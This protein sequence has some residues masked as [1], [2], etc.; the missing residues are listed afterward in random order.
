M[1]DAYALALKEMHG[2][3]AIPGFDFENSDYVISFGSGLIDGWGAPVRMFRVHSS[4]KQRGVTLVQAEPRLSN[5][6]AKADKWLPIQPGTEAVLALGLAWVILTEGLYDRA[7]I[8]NQTA[9]FEAWKRSVIDNY[10]PDTVSGLTGISPEVIQ[11]VARDFAGSKR[12]VAVCGRGEGRTPASVEEVTA[13]HALNALVGNI[14]KRGGIRAFSELAY[15]RWPEPVM[16]AAAMNSLKAPRIDGAGGGKYPDTPHLLNRVPGAIA[17]ESGLEI[18][19]LFVVNA[20]PCYTLSDASAV[21]KAF[22]GIPYKVSFSTYMDETAE[23]ADLVLPNHHYLERYED[24]H[25]TAGLT[26]PIMGLARPVVDPQL[27]TRHTGDVIIDIAKEMK[28]SMAASFRWGSYTACLKQALGSRWNYLVRRGYL[29]GTHRT[30]GFTAATGKFEFSTVGGSIF[31]AP[32]GDEA[33]F[34]LLLVPN[35][36]MRL[37]AGA[38]GSP[39]F[40]VKTVSETVLLENDTLVEIHPATAAAQGLTDSQ[41]A[42]LKTPRGEKKVKVHL[43]EG[44]RPGVISLPRGLGHTAYDKYLAD[45]GI[46][47]NELIGPVEDPASGMDVAWGIRASL[48]RA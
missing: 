44:I 10:S 29:P 4:W 36:S 9:G 41:Y 14:N 16:D 46:N 31:V 33:S 35:D 2:S 7:F 1:S 47:Y 27:N 12:P 26:M 8:D 40:L 20:N 11:G 42:A 19:A 39:P 6:A 21:R 34:P 48:T 32:E 25:V 23:M 17:S 5:T 3:A 45:K 22:E 13:I 28:G 37:A 24:V 18:N 43:T 38:I 15:R 30:A